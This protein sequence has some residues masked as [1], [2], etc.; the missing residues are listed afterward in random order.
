MTTS[1]SAAKLFI[2]SWIL[3]LAKA[4][5]TAGQEYDQMI[6]EDSDYNDSYIDVDNEA[7]DYDPP[8]DDAALESI[9]PTEKSVFRFVVE[10]IL[11]VS[12][13]VIGILG[14]IF[15]IIVL[16]RSFPFGT[17]NTTGKIVTIMIVKWQQHG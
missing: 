16:T 17:H 11:L 8:Y 14:N 10:G 6:V 5:T 2:T 9:G 15:A 1:V 7:E 12:V 3:L 4:K 13:S